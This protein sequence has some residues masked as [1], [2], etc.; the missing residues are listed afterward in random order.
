MSHVQSDAVV[1]TAILLLCLMC[2][3]WLDIKR[4][5]DANRDEGAEF[6]KKIT[7]HC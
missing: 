1:A 2:S 3:L 6:K 5:K 7:A 4:L